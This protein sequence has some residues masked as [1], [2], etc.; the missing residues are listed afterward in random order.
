MT[1]ETLNHVN[2]FKAVKEASPKLDWE[3][4]DK[5]F[6]SAGE[7]EATILSPVGSEVI[8]LASEASKP[9]STVFIASC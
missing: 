2:L 1:F 5:K 3:K 7:K 4:T 6:K 9:F 8:R